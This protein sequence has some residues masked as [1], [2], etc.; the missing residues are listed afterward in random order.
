M[1]NARSETV[2]DKP[3]FRAAAT[4]RRCVVPADGYYE[5]M[6]HS[7]FS[8]Q[9]PMCPDLPCQPKRARKTLLAPL[10]GVQTLPGSS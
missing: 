6:K 4:K 1:F 10:R 2:T 9:R 5:W 3:A 7:T 8:G